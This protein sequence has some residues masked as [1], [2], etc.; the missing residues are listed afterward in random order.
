MQK[1]FNHIFNRF[2][3]KKILLIGDLILDVYLKGTCSRIAPEASVP[4][5]DLESTKQCLGGAA[6]VAAN[7]NALGAEVFFISVT[8]NDTAADQVFELLNQ[9]DVS[10]NYIVR[11][12]TRT[13]LKKTRVTSDSHTI[14]RFDE[15]STD[16]IA[17]ISEER[18]I[19]N[20][21]EIYDKVDAILISD[22]AKGVITDAIINALSNLNQYGNKFIALDT[23]NPERYKSLKPNLFKPNYVEA[24]SICNEKKDYLNRVE[25]A[26][27]WGEKLYQITAAEYITITLDKDGVCCF[28]NGKFIFHEQV[29][30]VTNPRV[31]GA[32]DTFLSAALM[33]LIS[34]VAIWQTV[35]LAI[36]AASYAIEQENT[37][38]CN[39][40]NLR[41]HYS[42]QSKLLSNDQAIKDLVS[43]YKALGKKIVFTNGCFDILHSG[44]VSYLKGSKSKGDILIV[45]LNNDESIKRLKGINRPIN[46]LEDRIEVLS[47]L[48]CIDH[49]I[50]FGKQGDDTPI[51]ILSKVKPHVFVKGG[52]YRHKYLPEEVL[53]KK[54]GCEIVFMPMIANKSTTNVISQIQD[55]VSVNV[56]AIN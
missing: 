22:Y 56:S 55:K 49:I 33:S 27:K 30:Q 35:E 25:A 5:I 48:A 51:N 16:F 4:I 43:H 44:H 19:K 11:D 20:I 23:K 18:V 50:P 46:K 38:L 45:G 26:Q 37:A 1:D 40:D 13:T 15:G 14:V 47:E 8:G 54:M 21:H 3:A 12:S 52:D 32:G 31:S 34:G 39:L 24:A 6:N 42:C 10:N 7:L 53:L 28:Q 2:K 9:A 36:T 17:Q 41:F 29:P